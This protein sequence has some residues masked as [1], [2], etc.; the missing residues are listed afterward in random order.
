[1]SSI[2][3]NV[4][5][6]DNPGFH[7]TRG[8][9]YEICTSMSLDLAVEKSKSLR[10]IVLIIPYGNFIND[11]ANAV[12]ALVETMKQRFP[13]ILE[14]G[15]ESHKAFHILITKYTTNKQVTSFRNRIV[16]HIKEE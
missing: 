11:K 2:C 10:A 13:E 14:K 7:D 12:L 1:M 15:T 8:T 4:V 9:E 16:Q 5:L 3:K 6:C